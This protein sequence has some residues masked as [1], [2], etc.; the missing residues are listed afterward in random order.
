MILSLNKTNFQNWR[1]IKEV[2][3]SIL[4]KKAIIT[5][6]I[7]FISWHFTGKNVELQIKIIIFVI[8]K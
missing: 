2:S 1:N 5:I 3:S 4:N 7:P 8:I 6:T